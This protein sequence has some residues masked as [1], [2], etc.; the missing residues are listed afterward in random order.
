MSAIN[1]IGDTFSFVV[2]DG[3]LLAVN[4]K[5]YNR[6][7]A[8]DGTSVIDS[9]EAGSLYNSP[10]AKKAAYY[11]GR[12]YLANFRR[13][14]I[15]YKTTVLR[16]S[17]ALGIV[18]LVNGDVTA[19]TTIQVTDT[20][21]FYSATGMNQYDIYRGGTKIGSTLTVT[22]VNE[23]S[24]VVSGAVTLLS[25]DEIWISGTFNGTKQYRW[26]NNPTST[27]KDVKQ[28]D[29]FKLSGGDE[30]EMTLMESI[31][32]ILLLGNSNTLLSWNDYTLENF[33]LGIGCASLNGA[34]KL[35]GTL[36]FIHYSG[37]YATTGTTPTLLSRKRERYLRGATKSG[38]V[39]KSAVFKGLS[40]FFAIG[41]VTLY[42]A[43]GSFWKTLPN[44]CLE[45]TVTDK[46]WYVHTNVPSS[47][48][49]N[50]IN[51]QGTERL[52][53][54]HNNTGKSIKEFLV[55]NTDD[56]AEIFF[57][58]DTND[59]QF[60]SEFEYSIHP[61][62]VI[63]ELHRG[64]LMTTMISPDGDDF[65]EI[66]GTNK[67]GISTLKITARDKNNMQPI[68]CHK[69]KLSFRD[70]SKQLCRLVQAAI[71]YASTSLSTPEE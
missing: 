25:S 44:V 35:L 16:S 39:Y 66:E 31:G 38:I 30:D 6:L 42:N 11:K 68:S 45:Y 36:Y 2:A 63:T 58:A 53:F 29:T 12:M 10:R 60:M 47:Q 70:S 14:A 54:E 26:V 23:T 4:G 59:I 43:D 32:N 28:Y 40:I 17:Y 64:S 41:D 33:D 56:G 62:N 21:Y 37:V 34:V 3:S 19:S 48:F 20:K 9:S 57:R 61:K 71:V 22:T 5:D 15:Q 27:G 24:I 67:K 55:G 69:M 7:I 52:L 46:N 65:Y 49:L 50:F 8:S 51:K 18:A 1:I 13:N